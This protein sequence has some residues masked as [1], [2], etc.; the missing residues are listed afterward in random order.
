MSKQEESVAQHRIQ[1]IVPRT[2]DQMVGF[3]V[4]DATVSTSIQND[5]DL[6]Q[7][8]TKAV[9]KW[10]DETEEGKDVWD[11]CWEDLNIGDLADEG[12]RPYR[13]RGSLPFPEGTR[14]FPTGDRYV[15]VY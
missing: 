7:A 13:A 9:T 1:V 14:Y 8:L 15:L 3:A 5:Y 10:I 6:H 4:L 11:G 12:G 2:Y